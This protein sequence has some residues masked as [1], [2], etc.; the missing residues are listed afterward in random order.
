MIFCG[1]LYACFLTHRY[2]TATD[3][4]GSIATDFQVA[5]LWDIQAAWSSV[6]VPSF[7]VN[8]TDRFTIGLVDRRWTPTGHISGPETT[9]PYQPA[10]LPQHTR[11]LAPFYRFHRST[12]GY[13]THFITPA[14]T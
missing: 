1:G 2:Y 8:T 5:L 7:D 3:A 6:G 13:G 9:L 10:A 11:P 14:F 12:Y 4:R